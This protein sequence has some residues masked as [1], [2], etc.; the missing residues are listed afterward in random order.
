[1]IL[2]L[3]DIRKSY[4]GRY[5]LDGINI[6]PTSCRVYGLLGASGAGKTTLLN[7]ISGKIRPD[8]GEISAD[9]EPLNRRKTT[10]CTL[11]KR[12]T[13]KRE[14]LE[15]LDIARY[16]GTPFKA[17][18]ECARYLYRVAGLLSR[19]SDILLLDE[20]FAMLDKYH[21]KL[22]ADALKEYTHEG[23]LVIVTGRRAGLL[24]GVCDD[25]AVICGGKAV[26]EGG[27][28][29]IK[30]DYIHD[31]LLVRSK[32]CDRIEQE[33]SRKM[34]RLSLDTLVVWLSYESEKDEVMRR[35]LYSYDI[36]ELCVQTPTLDDIVD[37]YEKKNSKNLKKE[38]H[39]NDDSI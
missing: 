2:E 37:E 25:V 7:I 15:A 36:D 29:D 22:L 16:A 27:V 13:P 35:L 3:H 17:V 4:G 18:P 28:E 31:K 12:Y 6:E 38:I 39:D 33:F 34:T 32:D 20:P 1:M 5:I 23:A 9:E 14:A 24:D 21:S 11:S 19:R 10:V 8:S 30:A 26:L